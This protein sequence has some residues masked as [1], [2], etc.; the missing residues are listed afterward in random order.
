MLGKVWIDASEFER[1]SNAFNKLPEAMR[2]VAFRRAMSRMTTMARTRV[3]RRIAER[4]SIP[5]KYVREVTGARFSQ[6]D[7]SIEIKVRSGWIP[8]Y[9][10]GANQNRTGVKVRARGSYRHAFI[11]SMA[12]GHTG[13]FRRSGTSRLPIHELFGPNPAND[14]ATSPAEY[15]Q[16]AVELLE[17]ALV[18]RL[19]HELDRLLPK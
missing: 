17:E 19:A 16:V 12:S 3:V 2:Y 18:P 5:Q 10:F 1:T 15:E 11:A 6:V 13:V 9:K 4:V 14:V 8:L 7:N